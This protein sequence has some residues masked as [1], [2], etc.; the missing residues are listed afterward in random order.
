MKHVIAF[1]GSV[2]IT[3]TLL[4]CAQMQGA[5]KKA[6][7]DDKTMDQASEAAEAGSDE[8]NKA[9][10]N[11]P[12]NVLQ[13]A[14]LRGDHLTL[15]TA[16]EKAGLYNTLQGEGPFTLFAPTDA[17][18]REIPQEERNA[19]LDNE[20]PVAL[21]ALLEAHVV[22]GKLLVSDL[23]EQEALTTVNGRV[24]ALEP[25]GDKRSVKVAGTEIAIPDLVAS[26]GVVHVI[27]AVLM[28]AGEGGGAE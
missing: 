19:L 9:V 24:L 25:S 23:V 22:E 27:D 20:D 17:A 12:K 13:T 7:V 21:K 10:E 5:A 1:A 18:F 3:L 28:P 15:I 2:T 26:N 14:T 4:A 8:A 6:G 11:A 16:L